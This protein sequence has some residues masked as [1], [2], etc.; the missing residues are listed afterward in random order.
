VRRV[1]QE[2]L[3]RALSPAD[4][5]AAAVSEPRRSGAAS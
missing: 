4:D 1:V 2:V 3:R 5:E